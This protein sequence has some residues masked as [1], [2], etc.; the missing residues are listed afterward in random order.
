MKYGKSEHRNYGLENLQEERKLA[1]DPVV[2]K[3]AQIS[4]DNYF[5]GADT[6]KK[7][8]KERRRERRK[9]KQRMREE[10]Y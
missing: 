4:I 2:R 10:E 8:R 1:T 5:F 7:S 3:Q 9:E 6:R